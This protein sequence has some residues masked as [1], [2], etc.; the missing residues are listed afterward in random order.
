MKPQREGGGSN[1]Y[2]TDIPEILKVNQKELGIF[3]LKII[4]LKKN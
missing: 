2:G 3:I 1:V 4:S